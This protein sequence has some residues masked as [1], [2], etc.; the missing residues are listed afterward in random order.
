MA[1]AFTHHPNSL[2]IQIIFI[3]YLYS[4]RLVSI[5]RNT[6]IYK[7]IS[8][9]TYIY[10][11]LY[12]NLVR[13]PAHTSALLEMNSPER[14]TVPFRLQNVMTPPLDNLSCCGCLPVTSFLKFSRNAGKKGGD[15]WSRQQMEYA[16][17][18]KYSK[19]QEGG[20]EKGR[21]MRCLESAKKN[22]QDV[23]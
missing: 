16:Q 9:S 20:K 12:T 3:Q 18:M 15:V 6:H 21:R 8:I 10:I 11:Y 13:T 19:S 7:Y 23:K 22:A 2:S 1:I 17:N 14:L 4:F 5:T